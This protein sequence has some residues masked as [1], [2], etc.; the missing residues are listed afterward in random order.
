MKSVLKGIGVA[1]II[2]LGIIG[3]MFLG[4][5]LDL[6]HVD[7][8]RFVFKNSVTYTEGVADDLAKYQH[9]FSTSEDDT[10]KK[11]IAELVT[12]RFA[13]INE[14]NIE[15]PDLRE[16]LIKCRKGDID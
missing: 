12:S 7:A 11:A 8:D 15:S 14:N 5:A 9:E 16:F 13:N 1:L 2:I 6:F 3:M 10:D 4:V